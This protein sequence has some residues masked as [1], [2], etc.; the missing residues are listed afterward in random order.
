ML[1]FLSAFLLP[2][3]AFSQERRLVVT[4][5]A[6]YFGSDY[7]VRKD[8][9]LDQCKAA[10]QGDNQCQAFTYNT[11][12]RWCFLKSGVGELRAVAGAVSGRIV[13]ASAEPRP[14]VAAER[15]GELG[16]LDQ[17]YIDEARHWSA[18]IPTSRRPTRRP[19]R[20][21]GSPSAK[22]SGDFSDRARP[23]HRRAEIRA[24]DFDLWM[25]F[26]DTAINASSDD[27]EVQQTL[28]QPHLRRDQRLSPRR[29]A[30][31]ARACAGQLGWSLGDH[32][33]WKQAIR[34]YRA[35][36]ALVETNRRAPPTRTSSPSTASASSTIPSRPTPQRRA[37]A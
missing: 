9:D 12:A 16:F 24:D 29:L 14:D 3:T 33:D 28:R 20:G 15:I 17:S 23:L 37:S 13:A 19:T 31:G 30:G 10:C 11:T 18:R 2:P 4:E 32:Y 36:L 34:A 5:G 1:V 35:S 8:V 25:R 22:E 6:D 26:T 7:D 27:Y 21:R